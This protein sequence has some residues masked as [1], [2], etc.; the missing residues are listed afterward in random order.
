VTT[1]PARVRAVRGTA[2]G[3]DADRGSSSIE[4][5]IYTPVLMLVIFLTVQ[6]ALTWHGNQIAGAVA[7]ETARVVRTG[8][9]TPQSL[10]D[11]SA[12]GAQYAA[13]LGGSALTGVEIVVVQPDD[14]TV[15]VTVTGR[16]VEIV[17]GF[18]PKVSATVQGPIESFRPD[19]P[20]A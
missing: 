13:A 10:A 1:T 8:G 14:L 11:A 5:V 7:R 9:G 6:F 4:L 18:A 20:D 12:K 15:R 17:Q 2:L 3:P 16:S 19:R